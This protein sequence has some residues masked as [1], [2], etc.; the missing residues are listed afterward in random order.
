MS[1][2]QAD[3]NTALGG[4]V[5][6]QLTTPQGQLATTYTAE[7]GDAN[8]TFLYYVNGVD[9]AYNSGRMQDGIG[10]IYFMTRIAASPTFQQCVCTG[11][12]TTPIGIGALASDPNTNLQWMCVQAG[13]IGAG[14]TVTLSF[15]CTTNG[16]I[17]GP[18]SLEIQ[19]SIPGWESVAPTGDAV[20]GNNVE[21]PAQFEARREAS[22]AANSISTP[23]SIQGAVLGLTGVLDAYVLDNPNGTVLVVGGVSI[24]PHSIYACVLGGS[25]AA[26]AMA[27]WIKKPPGCAYNGNTT[28]TVTD[29]N[30][31]Y[32]PP[33]PTYQ[34]SYTTPTIEAFA[35]L[36]VLKNNSGVPANATALVAL[37]SSLNGTGNGIIAGFAGLDGGTRAKIGSTIFA[38][39]YYGDVASLGTWALIVSIQIG[40]S[41][42]ASTFQGSIAGTTLTVSE[43]VA[44]LLA[45]GQL[46]QDAGIL[47]QGTLIVSQ[48]SGTT[49]GTGTYQLS[50][51]QTVS[52][53]AMNATTLTDFVAMGISQ[54]PAVSQANIQLLLE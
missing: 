52:S 12:A 54:A 10:R 50:I 13:E 42:Q 20:L 1:G 47:A 41:G 21:T 49:G 25:S 35:F 29:P 32:N 23:D 8:V 37:G 27:I 26:V 31:A 14:G 17:A 36:V 43:I 15:Q 48:L 33:A 44:G 11:L 22:V 2:V 38:S 18:E 45:P 7:I 30:P 46:L 24:G 28:V 4:N 53:E 3:I 34:V 51:G 40:L 19:Q 39:R 9:P 16:P 5:N 6:P